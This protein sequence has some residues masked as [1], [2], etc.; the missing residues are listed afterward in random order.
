M[1]DGD[2]P[3][4]ELVEGRESTKV[5]TVEWI[6]PTVPKKDNNEESNPNDDEAATG[7]D[8]ESSETALIARYIQCVVQNNNSDHQIE[9]NDS[10]LRNPAYDDIAILLR[11]RGGLRALECSLNEAHIRF[12]RF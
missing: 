4:S 5:G 9:E 11:S 10:E 2:S 8:D 6:C 1:H 12:H 3:Y 7:F